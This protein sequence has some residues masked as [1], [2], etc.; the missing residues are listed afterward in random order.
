MPLITDY[1][2]AKAIRMAKRSE[3]RARHLSGQEQ[4][5]R[6]GDPYTAFNYGEGM[7]EEI[8]RKVL[9][10]MI[11]NGFMAVEV[12]EI[13]AKETGIEN[14]NVKRFL[15]GIKSGMWI[16][17]L[18]HLLKT[19]NFSIE[20]K[21]NGKHRFSHSV[22]RDRL[23]LNCNRYPE[24]YLNMNTANFLD[25]EVKFKNKAEGSKF[26]IRRL[27]RIFKPMLEHY[28]LTVAKNK[29]LPFNYRL[30]RIKFESQIIDIKEKINQL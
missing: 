30:A 9:N 25:F 21:F 22:E 15:Y 4:L 23:I 3:Y 20:V 19:F 12:C 28:F 14:K 13:W 26:E 11:D 16:W 8:T 5:T 18:K 1:Q 24:F 10:T 17:E 27:N 2:T 6:D 7:Q 29:K